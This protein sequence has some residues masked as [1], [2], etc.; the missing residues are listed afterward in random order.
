MVTVGSLIRVGRA[1]A[2]PW[3]SATSAASASRRAWYAATSSPTLPYV[4]DQGA[5]L[6]V[7]LQDRASSASLAARVCG[8]HVLVRERGR[9]DGGVGLACSPE[10]P[11]RVT[12]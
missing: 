10:T 11:A 1:A 4:G 9:G 8:D 5:D 2:V 7:G 6:G 3:T 12:A